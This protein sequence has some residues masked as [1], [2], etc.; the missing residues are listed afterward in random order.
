MTDGLD[1]KKNSLFSFSWVYDLA[2]KLY[3]EFYRKNKKF[4]DEIQ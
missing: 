3:E 1:K 2:E 4:F